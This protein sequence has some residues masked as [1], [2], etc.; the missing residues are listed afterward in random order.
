MQFKIEW[1]EEASPRGRTPEQELEGNE[2]G[3]P[4]MPGDTTA[5][6]ENRQHKGCEQELTSVFEKRREV[7]VAASE[8]ES[9]TV[10]ENASRGNKILGHGRP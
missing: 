6:T 1:L 9:R 7:V 10:L 3:S 4:V 5:V 2:G 8:W